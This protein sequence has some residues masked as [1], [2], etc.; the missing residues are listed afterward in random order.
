V[1][2]KKLTSDADVDSFIPVVMMGVLGLWGN[3]G[4]SIHMREVV[5]CLSSC[6]FKP[7]VVCLKSTEENDNE[8]N[9]KEILIPVIKKRFLLQLSLN[10]FGTIRA[11]QAV[12]KSGANII[13]T[14]LD[15]GVFS[16]LLAALITRSRLVV[17][18]NGLPTLDLQLYRPN[19]TILLLLSKAWE[20]LHYKVADVIVGAPGYSNYVMKHFNV[21]EDKLHVVPLGVNTDVFTPIDRNEALSDLQIYDRPTVVWVGSIAGWQGLECLLSVAEGLKK[22]VPMCQVR[23]VGDGP[24][25]GK[26]KDMVARLHLTNMVTFVGKVPYERVPLEISA[27]TVCVCTF[28]GN[29]GDRFSISGLKTL[30]YL[31]CGRPVVTTKMD[32][33]APIIEESGAGLSVEPDSVDEMEQAISTLL[34]E[35]QLQWKTRCLYAKGLIDKSRTWNGISEKIGQKLKTLL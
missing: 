12:R 23:I 11:I 16:G 35:D 25:L 31:S 30:N 28:P 10:L 32:E 22:S 24:D 20:T 7:W 19:N 15:P 33:M 13:Y 27:A 34:L 14:R 9:I 3:S 4:A 8:Q 26:L 5:L 1:T 17:E 29:R 6:G 2:L 18:M 21:P